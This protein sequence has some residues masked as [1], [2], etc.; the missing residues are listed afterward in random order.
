M[1]CKYYDCSSLTS[2]NIPDGVTSIWDRAFYG[3]SSLTSITIPDG[4]TSI[5]DRAF[6]GCSSLTS[7]TLLSTVPCEI[8]E[9]VFAFTNDCPIYVPSGSVNAYKEAWP[10]WAD[11]IVGCDLA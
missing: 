6:Y 10:Q 11:R 5:W 4:V 9:D 8:G 7:I 1:I 3:C 2:I